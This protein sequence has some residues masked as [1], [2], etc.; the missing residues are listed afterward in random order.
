[1][2]GT[3]AGIHL[4]GADRVEANAGCGIF[5]SKRLDESN[6]SRLGRGIVGGISDAVKGGSGRGRYD[7]APGL[8]QRGNAGLDDANGADQ[9]DGVEVHPVGSGDV[10]EMRAAVDARVAYQHVELA[11]DC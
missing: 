7:V 2:G 9:V 5:D 3:H 11:E 6:Y 4:A 10:G 1:D 8:P